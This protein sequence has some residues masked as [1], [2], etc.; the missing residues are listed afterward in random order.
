MKAKRRGR[1]KR[2]SLRDSMVIFLSVGERKSVMKRWKC[3]NRCLK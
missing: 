2:E 3:R 1:R